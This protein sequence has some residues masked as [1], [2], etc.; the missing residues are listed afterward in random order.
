MCKPIGKPDG[1]K[2]GRRMVDLSTVAKPIRVHP[3]RA[4]Y[5]DGT[6]IIYPPE[7]KGSK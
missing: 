5:P 1:Y 7:P 6:V 3:D 4:V 2:D